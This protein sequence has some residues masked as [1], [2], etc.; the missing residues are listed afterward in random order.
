MSNLRWS[1]PISARE[2]GWHYD[3]YTTGV[4]GPVARVFECRELEQMPVLPYPSGR[5]RYLYLAMLRSPGR[6]VGVYQSLRKAKVECER[7]W[8]QTEPR[9]ITPVCEARQVSP[10][11][12]SGCFDPGSRVRD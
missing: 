5:R 6:V 1:G 3:A 8:L 12:F 11:R 10:M 7:A 2:I 9:V 4:T